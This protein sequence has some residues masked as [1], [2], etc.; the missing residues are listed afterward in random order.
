MQRYNYN[1]PSRYILDDETVDTTAIFQFAMK[2]I[3]LLKKLEREKRNFLLSCI[4]DK[5]GYGK[6]KASERKYYRIIISRIENQKMFSKTFLLFLNIWESGEGDR[7][8]TSLYP[9]IKI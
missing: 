6:G 4:L 9:E 8:L 5:A 7:L 3:N 2:K 1:P